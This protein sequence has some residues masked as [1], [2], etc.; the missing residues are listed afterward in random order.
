M[1]ATRNNFRSEQKSKDSRR[2]RRDISA[3]PG[4]V[5]RHLTAET[6]SE[7][8][9][10]TGERLLNRFELA[11]ALRVSVS[12]VDRMLA[13]D[14]LPR[15]WLRGRVR[16]HLPDVMEWLRTGNRKYG[17]RAALPGNPDTENRNPKG[18]A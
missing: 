14:D 1:L 9:G 4:R 10:L 13:N 2:G 15:M 8:V 12:T 11:A 5:A 7:D 17:R 3:Q 6:R 16:F 18:V